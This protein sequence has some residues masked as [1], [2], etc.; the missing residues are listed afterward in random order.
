MKAKIYDMAKLSESGKFDTTIVQRF[1]YHVKDYYE[2]LT[3]FVENHKK[4]L[5][6]YTPAFVVNSEDE[7]KG[8]LN[9][10]FQVRAMLMRLGAIDLLDRLSAMEDAAISRNFQGFSDGQVSFNATLKIY[11][12]IIKEAEGT[13]KKKKKNTT[14]SMVVSKDKPTILVVEPLGSDLQKIVELLS[15]EYKVLGCPDGQSAIASLRART[16]DLFLICAYMPGISGYELAFLI[17]SSGL[18]TPIWFMSD[19][20]IFDPVQACMPPEVTQYITKPL[21]GEKVLLMLHE[22]F[23]Q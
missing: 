22:H 21:V 3:D 17:R 8:F 7:R 23:A 11:M 6:H 18:K 4:C 16:P 20:K 15:G 12:D 9:E 2:A 1:F 13:S 10:C 5:S 19:E 14:V